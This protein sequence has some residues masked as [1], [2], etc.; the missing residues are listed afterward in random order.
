MSGDITSRMVEI[1]NTSRSQELTM[2]SLNQSVN[3]LQ[4]LVT[5]MM[6]EW[7]RFRSGESTSTGHQGQQGG[8]NGGFYG[9]SNGGSQ[10]S[11]SRTTKIEFPK[12]GGGED[13]R[14]WLFKC[15]QFFRVDNIHDN[16]KVNLVSIHLSDLALMWHRQVVRHLG[17]DVSWAMY[18]ETIL[19]R[20]GSVYDDPLSEIKKLKQIGTVQDYID[21]YDR[22]LCRVDLPDDQSMS[23][24]MA[25]L[26]SE[27]ELAVRMFRPRSLTDLYGLCKLEEAKVNVNKLK[28]R[29]PIL[30]TPRFQTP[31]PN[32]GPKP[33]SLPT[34]NLNWRNKAVINNPL[35]KQLTQKELE[36]KRAKNQC[37]YCRS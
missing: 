19:K 35:R 31:L 17:E 4:Q 6:N 15:E 16:Q 11:F 36:E 33:V 23:F 5:N 10:M 12:F 18:R 1:R 21:A 37:F 24:F 3:D 30:P 8:S 28:Y 29:P 9:G 25:G 26:K 2:E 13:V 34:P 27:I 7:S 14:N 32:T 20:F 22:L